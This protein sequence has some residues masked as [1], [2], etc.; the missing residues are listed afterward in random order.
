MTSTLFGGGEGTVRRRRLSM[1]TAAAY[2]GTMAGK[3]IDS[4]LVRLPRPRKDW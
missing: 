3:G 2:S 4:R 1:A